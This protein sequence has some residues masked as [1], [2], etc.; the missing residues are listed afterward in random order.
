MSS[1]FKT[2]DA[3]LTFLRDLCFRCSST[4]SLFNRSLVSLSKLG[5][6]HNAPAVAEPAPLFSFPGPAFFPAAYP[7]PG[8]MCNEAG[9]VGGRR[10]RSQPATALLWDVGYKAV[11]RSLHSGACPFAVRWLLFS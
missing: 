7:L 3:A 9:W 8:P 6:R 5:F 11:G 2:Y 1:A 4:F 10:R